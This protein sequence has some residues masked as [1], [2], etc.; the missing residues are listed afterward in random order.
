MQSFQGRVHYVDAGHKAG[1][2]SAFF[3]RS[4][5]LMH[6][7]GSKKGQPTP[8]K[9]CDEN[10]LLAPLALPFVLRHG[11]AGPGS[12]EGGGGGGKTGPS[13]TGTNKPES[14]LSPL[15]QIEV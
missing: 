1:E 15:M 12:G 4:Q 2:D 6:K 3:P 14:Y 13:Q 8:G 7:D 9:S 11:G 10:M 5:S